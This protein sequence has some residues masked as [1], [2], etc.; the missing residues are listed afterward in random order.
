ML[1]QMEITNDGQLRDKVEISIERLK[2]FEPEEGYYLAFSGGKDSQ[3]VYHLAKMAGVKFDAHYNV[4][5]V[6]PPELVKFIQK[7]YPDVKFEHQRNKDGDP[8]TM[9]N[10]IAE[11]GIP[12]TRTAR[13][14]CEKLKESNG[15]YR[16]TVTGVRR[17]ESV[18]RAKN[19]GVATIPNAGKRVLKYFEE[20]DA[21]YTVT[22]K[23]GIIL[24]YD[25]SENAQM[26]T[27][28]IRTTK[29]L[30]NPIYDW[31]EEDVWE[32]LNSNE[33]PHCSLYDEGYKRLGCIGCPMGRAKKQKEQFERWPKY[34]ELYLKAFARMIKTR[35]DKGLPCENWETPEKVMSWWLGETDS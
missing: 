31:T 8:Y 35:Q 4:T 20:S 18:N 7:N 29:R 10:L 9:W 27:H 17:E 30:V 28:C 12:P 34:K 19:Q 13:F 2:A 22:P 14:C 32:F 33:I 1:G 26:I 21:D 11:Q 25:N 6:D 24:N 16:I 3:C 15:K 5:S 23:G